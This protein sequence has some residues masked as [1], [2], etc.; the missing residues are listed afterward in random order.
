M[1]EVFFP[2]GEGDSRVD[3]WELSEGGVGVYG[4]EWGGGGVVG[5]AEGEV[6]FFFFR[7]EG[8]K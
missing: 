2:R 4:E 8:W 5:A 1:C 6:G 7:G 3:L